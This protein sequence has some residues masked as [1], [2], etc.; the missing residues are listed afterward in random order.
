MPYFDVELIDNVY[1]S[2]VSEYTQLCYV[3]PRNSL[4]YLPQHIYNKLLEKYSYLYGTDYTFS[5][6][7]CKYFWE[8]H[9]N[10][11]HIDIKNIETLLETK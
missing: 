7:F 9:V 4:H 1:S 6:S 2:P 8:C 10:L 3:L 11:P 5:W